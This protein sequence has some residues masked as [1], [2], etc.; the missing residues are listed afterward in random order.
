MNGGGYL[1]SKS[2]VLGNSD[3]MNK[4]AS[5]L[6]NDKYKR[7]NLK[8]I[9]ASFKLKNGDIIISPVKIKMHKSTAIF[10]GKQSVD[11]TMDYRLQIEIPYK[12][13]TG[14]SPVIQKLKNKG[15]KWL[16][17]INP[18]EKIKVTILIKGT[19][20]EPKV[21]LD[22]QGYVDR[23]KAK[24]VAD[25]KKK[26]EKEARKQADKILSEADKQAAKLLAEAQKKAM[27]IRKAGKKAAQ[28]VVAEADKKIDEMVNKA[29]GDFAKTLAKEAGKK[30]K[31][32]AR[33]K[34]KNIEAEANKR[35]DQLVNETKKQ[36]EKIKKQARE[37][38]DKLIRE[39]VD[40][41]K[42]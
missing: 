41:I 13:L 33:K 23:L 3:T 8:N 26:A 31:K 29:H 18:N 4:I 21:S 19:L 10:S 37:K 24:I 27:D 20:K 14:M 9:K 34:A 1:S 35:A 25:L 17:Y 7:L 30:L 38:A 32:E 42:L 6:K 40:A 16:K 12:E 2:I 39:A 11:T 15:D 22:M 5:L 36:T 28:K